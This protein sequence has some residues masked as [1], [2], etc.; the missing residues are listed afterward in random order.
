MTRMNKMIASTLLA[1]APLLLAAPA[2]ALGWT[3]DTG[4]PDASG[5]ALVLD[6]ANFVA[7]QVSFG[8]N[9]RLAAVQAYIT[10]GNSGE[11]FTIVLYDNSGANG[12][13][14]DALDSTSASF[15][16][17]GWN[18]AT[19]LGWALTPGASYWLAIE[20]RDSDTL[21][22]SSGALLPT[23]L[24]AG[25][26]LAA[27]AFNSSFRYEAASGNLQFGL[28]AA[29]VPEASSVAMLLAGLAA[30]GA[31]GATRRRDGSHLAA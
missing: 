25:Q 17:D 31:V 1:A 6:S 4:A 26:R 14:G 21:G 20:M 27:T 8:Q 13:P 22:N 29:A 15:T 2:Q 16:A 11:T 9:N 18:G 23:G 10:G 19:S 5:L 3:V 24:A 7:G 28:Q 30:L 12:L